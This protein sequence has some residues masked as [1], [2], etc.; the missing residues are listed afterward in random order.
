M[1]NQITRLH[2]RNYRSLADID[3]EAGAINIFFGPNGS[4]KS[5]FLDAM[6]FLRDCVLQGVDA[7]SSERSH[8][9]GLR[10]DGAEENENITIVLENGSF[11]YETEFGYSSGRIE[12]FVGE[13]LYAKESHITLIKRLIGSDKASFYQ[14]KIGEQMSITLREPEKLALT[15]FPAFENAVSVGQIG[16]F[17]E[18]AIASMVA[19][20]GGKIENAPHLDRLLKN[21]QYYDAR[22][23]DLSR[24]RKLGSESSYHTLLQDH[25]RNLWSVLR[26][27]HDR[28]NV[29]GRYDTI[30]DFMRQSFPIFRDLLIEQTGPSTVYGSFL[31]RGRRHPIQA[32][33]VSSGHLQMLAHLTALF[34][35]GRDQET[36]IIFD[37]PETS[38]HPHALAVLAEA[39]HHAAQEW[40]KQIFL[41]T[42]SPVLMSQ[43]DPGQIFAMQLGSKGET[44][45]QRV[46]DIVNIQ[47]LLEEY[48]LGSLYMAEAVAPQSEG[49]V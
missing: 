32:S 18:Q 15:A 31:E 29:D 7:A 6:L 40:R 47:D 39:I 35:D 10:W 3:I 13:K 27:L 49:A 12:P 5:S 23:I 25:G 26:N 34:S 33:G 2:I 37:E 45:M 24:L 14:A 17:T 48:A 41:A 44:I 19:A 30:I 28:R 21:V 36:I 43:F 42:H 22:A 38:L 4:G 20:T 46:S 8:G 9:I 1:P 11:C 16:A